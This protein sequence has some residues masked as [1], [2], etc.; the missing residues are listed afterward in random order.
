MLIKRLTG[1]PELFF[2]T[3]KKQGFAEPSS[4]ITYHIT[5]LATILAV[6]HHAATAAIPLDEAVSAFGIGINR[7]SS[8]Q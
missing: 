7:I 6:L 4:K 1:I 3:L 2:K 8:Y 5:Y